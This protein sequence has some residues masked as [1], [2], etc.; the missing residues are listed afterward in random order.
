MYRISL[1]IVS[2]FIPI[3]CLDVKNNILVGTGLE[4]KVSNAYWKQYSAES[5]CK[6]GWAS[7]HSEVVRAC[8]Q[9]HFG[10]RKPVSQEKHGGNHKSASNDTASGTRRRI[11]AEQKS[12]GGTGPQTKINFVGVDNLSG[13]V[14]FT[15]DARNQ[16]K[17]R[18]LRPY[19]RRRF[20][21][22]NSGVDIATA[23]LPASR[24]IA[25]GGLRRYGAWL[26]TEPILVADSVE[27]WKIA[28]TTGHPHIQT[29]CL[30]RDGFNGLYFGVCRAPVRGRFV[31]RVLEEYGPCEGQRH[32][33]P[34]DFLGLWHKPIIIEISGQPRPIQDCNKS[35][36]VLTPGYWAGEAVL[37]GPLPRWYPPQCRCQKPHASSLNYGNTIGPKPHSF[38]MAGDSTMAQIYSCLK[39]SFQTPDVYTQANCLNFGKGFIDDEHRHIW[40]RFE[41][42]NARSSLEFVYDA[43]GHTTGNDADLMG[44]MLSAQRGG[45]SSQ[46][47]TFFG[48]SSPGGCGHDNGNQ[49]ITAHKWAKAVPD[50]S[51]LV[52]MRGLRC[53]QSGTPLW[54][55]IRSQQLLVSAI[56]TVAQKRRMPFILL[57]TN[58]IHEYS[59]FSRSS[60][61]NLNYKNDHVPIEADREI[62]RDA[63][64]YI[65]NGAMEEFAD[66]LGVH[67][68]DAYWPQ[69]S[70]MKL[71][72]VRGGTGN[73][74]AALDSDIRHHGVFTTLFT[75]GEIL[76]TVH[77]A[78][79]KCSD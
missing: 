53:M 49:S 8:Y 60:T 22:M 27:H 32:P 77:Q 26:R 47:T 79:T 58:A 5:A 25:A 42:G 72:G 33:M 44:T 12:S 73:E 75:I 64:S 7:Q 62:L 38:A 52:A 15:I 14:T 50:G 45:S 59:L 63:F 18:H 3:R 70:W 65:L 29:A 4:E 67:Y 48:L 39:G 46:A 11:L 57:S 23:H 41:R 28:P 21:N 1:L 9:K 16:Q 35:T 2:T 31:L 56:F 34:A 51:V 61:R 76:R 6:P 10:P 55:V 54:S 68:I 74:T 69:R 30:V 40:A 37:S 17:I 78:T 71:P 66:A 20:Q 36:D 43:K 19:L 13:V 24:P